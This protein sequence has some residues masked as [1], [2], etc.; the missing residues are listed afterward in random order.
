VQ[1]AI[2]PKD[3]NK[4]QPVSEYN[5][6]FKYESKVP[7]RSYKMTVLSYLPTYP[8][9]KLE[10][11]TTYNMHYP[12]PPAVIQP[13]IT[14][15]HRPIDT[16]RAGAASGK[17]YDETSH[18]I[19]YQAYDITKPDKFTVSTTLPKIIECTPNYLTSNKRFFPEWEGSNHRP[20]PYYELPQQHE[21]FKG[22]FDGLS[23]TKRDFV[24][25]PLLSL[26]PK[27]NCK[28]PETSHRVNEKLD[29]L[30]TTKESFSLPKLS[31]TIRREPLRLKN[32]PQK[33]TETMEPTTGQF[34][35][36]TQYKEDNPEYITRPAKRKMCRPL[37]EN[38]QLPKD[39]KMP[40]ITTQK[41]SYT[42]CWNRQPKPSTPFSNNAGVYQ[43]PLQ[44]LSNQTNYKTDFKPIPGKTMCLNKQEAGKQA[45]ISTNKHKEALEMKAIHTLNGSSQPRTTVNQTE[46][47]KFDKTK[48]RIRHGDKAEKIYQM[49]TVPFI[50]ISDYAATFIGKDG[51]PATIFKPIETRLENADKLADATSYKESY[52]Q[53]P[54]YPSNIC[55]AEILL[56]KRNEVVH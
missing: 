41:S 24:K 28:N 9:C 17:F 48:P 35:S 15:D 47:F 46:Y 22:K 6:S 53:L 11:T 7:R 36:I 25:I 50:A 8:E 40:S 3:V 52:I 10:G 55:P 51:K 27:V 19:D 56:R 16:Y 1:E 31:L 49:L 37:G 12:S 14:D 30:T 45:T 32:N 5:S 13:V 23:C 38:I 4:Y 34:Q 42:K 29:D 39:I 21:L 43:P 54:L 26:K 18:K 44:P 2:G 33:N 20:H